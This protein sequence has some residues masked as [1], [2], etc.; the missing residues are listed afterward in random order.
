MSPAIRTKTT[1]VFR[2]PGVNGVRQA[3]P[4]PRSGTCAVGDM[5]TRACG[6]TAYTVVMLRE[7]AEGVQVGKSINSKSYL[8]VGDETPASDYN[9][10]DL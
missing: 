6:N 10:Q 8:K 9:S 2:Q 3:L 7:F 1:A 4:P 5:S